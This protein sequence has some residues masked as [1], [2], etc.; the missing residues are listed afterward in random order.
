MPSSLRA[1][2]AVP[3]PNGKGPWG[4]TQSVVVLRR[5]GMEDGPFLSS[6]AIDR[7]SHSAAVCPAGDGKLAA[8]FKNLTTTLFA[9]PRGGTNATEDTSLYGGPDDKIGCSGGS[10]GTVKRL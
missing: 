1:G 4:G 10:A 8:F 6:V 9:E 3:N 5:E 2:S 7:L